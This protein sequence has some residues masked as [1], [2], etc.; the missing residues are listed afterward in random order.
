MNFGIPLTWV[1]LLQKLWGWMVDFVKAVPWQVWLALAL[2]FA[3]WRYGEA[4]YSAGVADERAVWTEW[5]EKQEEVDR[6][7]VAAQKLA[8]S[9]IALDTQA[10][11]QKASTDTRT[12]TAAAV[13][14]IRYVTR[15]IEVPAECRAAVQLPDSVRD[16]LTQAAARTRAAGDPMRAGANP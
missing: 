3:V 14:R 11:A 8:A 15:T 9:Q 7:L 2:A 13:E 4:Q 12:E 16:E 5:R 6:E 1:A 10:K